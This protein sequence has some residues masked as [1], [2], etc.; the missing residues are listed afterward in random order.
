M[1]KFWIDFLEWNSSV[2]VWAICEILIL[3]KEIVRERESSSV[4]LSWAFSHL[5]CIYPDSWTAKKYL[6][7]SF[8]RLSKLC[9]RIFVHLFVT[10]VE[11]GGLKKALSCWFLLPCLTVD[12]R[13]VGG[14]GNKTNSLFRKKC[15]IWHT[16]HSSK[17]KYQGFFDFG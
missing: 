9:N 11:W 6:S 7:D 14:F 17:I 16:E 8:I 15:R 4:K 1:L 3:K 12:L 10:R 5:L 2:K 13:S